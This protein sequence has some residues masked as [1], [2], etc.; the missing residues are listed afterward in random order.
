MRATLAQPSV[1]FTLIEM[2]VALV[3]AAMLAALAFPGYRQVMHR[4]Q[5]IEAHLALMRLQYLQER[6]FADHHAYA[7]ELRTDGSGNSLPIAAI[8]EDGNYE[9]SM[10]LD[11]GGQAYVAFARA[12]PS[13]RQAGDTPCQRFSIDTV[14]TRRSAAAAGPWRP[15]PGGG[16]WS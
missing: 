6:H 8:T 4:T 1:G 9:L 12:R 2:L 13:G 3:L 7:S 11:A 5:R 16:C 10:R 15:E 14:G